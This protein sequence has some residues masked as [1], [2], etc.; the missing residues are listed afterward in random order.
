MQIGRLMFQLEGYTGAPTTSEN[1]QIADVS[2]QLTEATAALDKL[3]NTEL[4][5]LNKALND[6]G[7]PHITAVPTS[8]PARR[9]E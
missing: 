6:A 2:K 3:I 1:E 4:A 5:R 9:F 7:V 8:P